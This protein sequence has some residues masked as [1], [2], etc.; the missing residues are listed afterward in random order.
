MLSTSG[1]SKLFRGLD[2]LGVLVESSTDPATDA[3]NPCPV[4]PVIRTQQECV[5]GYAYEVH[6][7]WILTQELGVSRGRGCPEAIQARE[8]QHG[9]HIN[10]QGL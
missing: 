1:W 3:E 2:L 6:P 10:F 5:L 8:M 9:S 7:L 4:V